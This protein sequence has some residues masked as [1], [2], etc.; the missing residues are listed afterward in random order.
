MS[1]NS[2]DEAKRVDWLESLITGYRHYLET[3]GDDWPR[4]LAESL[5][6]H[7]WP[8]SDRQRKSEPA[9]ETC[10]QCED[11]PAAVKAAV[12]AAIVADRL[13]YLRGQIRGERI[14]YDELAE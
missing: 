12:R 8:W 3:F 4:E 1:D 13:E 14:S 2:S 9:N 6:L 11:L 5:A 7:L 10:P